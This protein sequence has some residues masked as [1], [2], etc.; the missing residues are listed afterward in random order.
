MGS[1]LLYDASALIHLVPATVDSRA[2]RARA[3]LAKIV[4]GFA[5]HLKSF[6]SL[7]RSANPDFDGRLQIGDALEDPRRMCRRV[8]PTD[9]ARPGRARTRSR[10]HL[11]ADARLAGARDAALHVRLLPAP[12]VKPARQPV[13]PAF[14]DGVA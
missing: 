6:R 4:S 12:D 3:F 7:L 1:L 9:K 10:A 2:A 8:I 11:I 13:F 5:V 14:R